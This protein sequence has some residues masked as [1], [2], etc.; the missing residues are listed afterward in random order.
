[1]HR[2]HITRQDI[3]RAERHLHHHRHGHHRR[4]PAHGKKGLVHH[5][6]NDVEV[7]GAAFAAGLAKGYFG[8]LNVGPVPVDLLAYAGLAAANA[9][10]VVPSS[11]SHH[12]GNVARG[13]LASYATTLGAGLGDKL[14]EKRDPKTWIDRQV[15]LV[16]NTQ[17]SVNKLMATNLQPPPAS[18]T[19]VSGAGRGMRRGGSP[20]TETELR[21]LAESVR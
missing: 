14:L 21:A 8:P 7:G 9:L 13:V 16:N 17:T 6:L 19:K 18:A 11:M 10:G 1:M 20:L 15:S 12:V 5:L 3:E 4:D 2:F